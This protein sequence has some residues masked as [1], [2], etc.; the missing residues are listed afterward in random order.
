MSN[1][2][3]PADEDLSVFDNIVFLL[4]NNGNEFEILEHDFVHRSEDAAKVRGTNIQEVQ[5][6][7]YIGPCESDISRF[8]CSF[9]VYLCR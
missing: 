2:P 6:Y 4:N 8:Y 9:F 5:T 7:Y 1:P 3:N